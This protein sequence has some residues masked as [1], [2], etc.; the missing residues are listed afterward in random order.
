MSAQP[1]KLQK[2]LSIYDFTEDESSVYLNLLKKE[3][4]SALE[5]SKDLKI[6]RTR[7]YRVLEKLI[8][9]GFVKEEIK[10]YGTKFVAES[11][12]KLSYLIDEKE[13]ELNELRKVMP[14]LFYQLAM[15]KLQSKEDYRVL[16]YR[17]VEGLKQVTWNSLNSK[18]L[19]RIYEIN[20][21][22]A[23]LDKKFAEKVRMEFAK[24]KIKVHQLTNLKEI[25]DFTEIENHVKFWTPRYVDP[26]ELEMKFEIL[27]Y[28]DVYCMYSY[29]EEKKDIFCVEIHNSRLAKMQKQLFD[30]VWL[31]AN[32][33]KVVSKRGSSKLA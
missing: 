21:M 10:D 23:F 17:G 19:F 7:V 12:E 14:D 26:D 33:M 16:Y 6:P 15:L 1:D 31:K 22:N 27:I 5:I 18:G 30:F 28:N 25:K 3:R 8:E 32:K 4:S 20:D 11:Y 13:K 29:D 24:R 9:K 2:L